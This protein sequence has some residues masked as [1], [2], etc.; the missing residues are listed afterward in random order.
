MTEDK[1]PKSKPEDKKDRDGKA[2]EDRSKATAEAVEAGKV[3][4]PKGIP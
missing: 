1:T 3:E 4:A 2:S